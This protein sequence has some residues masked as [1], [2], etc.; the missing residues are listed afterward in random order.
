MRGCFIFILFIAFLSWGQQT[1]G[2]SDCGRAKI[3]LG[4]T[5]FK[6]ALEGYD[7]V[8]YE[9]M[10]WAK[11]NLPDVESGDKEVNGII[12]INGYRGENIMRTFH[13]EFLFHRERW[14]ADDKDISLQMTVRLWTVVEDRRIDLIDRH[15]KVAG[16]HE[17]QKLLPHIKTVFN[18]M[19]AVLAA[20]MLPDKVSFDFD[21]KLVK[22]DNP[23]DAEVRIEKIFTRHGLV[24]TEP[25]G[26]AYYC[27]E[28]VPEKGHMKPGAIFTEQDWNPK[29]GDRPPAEPYKMTYDT[30]E[31]CDECLKTDRYR[32]ERPETKFR[33]KLTK[34]F[35]QALTSH[36]LTPEKNLPVTCNPDIKAVA[37]QPIAPG[38][39]LPVPFRVSG[40]KDKVIADLPVEA[41]VSPVHLGNLNQDIARTDS[42]GMTGTLTFTAASNAGEGEVAS[43]TGTICR[44]TPEEKSAIQAF[45]VEILPEIEALVRSD[46]RID[47]YRDIRSIDDDG[48]DHVHKQYNADETLMLEFTVKFDQRYTQPHIDSAHGFKG[49]VLIYR[50][51]A[52][53]ARLTVTNPHPSSEIHQRR[54]QFR[55]SDCGVMNYDFIPYS[56]D[57][58][59]DVN[60]ARFDLDVCYFH[61]IPAPDSAARTLPTEGLY[62][63]QKNYQNPAVSIKFDM[64]SKSYDFN[65]Q[66]CSIQYSGYPVPAPSFPYVVGN[67]FP[68]VLWQFAGTECYGMDQFVEPLKQTEFRDMYRKVK[69]DGRTFDDLTF[70]KTINLQKGD[71][72]MCWDLE[73]E[74]SGDEIDGKVQ[75][76][77]SFLYQVKTLRGRFSF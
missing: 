23:V 59:I 6:N 63:L 5:F 71:R 64:S 65:G 62:F 76:K 61:Y 31:L 22:A 41:G 60:Q 49:E 55:D 54:G 33:I 28:V 10:F 38:E 25:G 68:L 16:R 58:F 51:T 15:Y 66:S 24:A 9:V 32:C 73:E 14:L 8:D 72:A 19:P 69:S 30:Q 36:F 4:G 18:E 77:V 2:S 48:F 74:E 7:P 26:D 43:V 53:N 37:V 57:H 21:P 13:L 35:N 1:M 12:Y 56:M 42:G 75:G 34:A 52:R 67:T 40:Y 50:G 11:E 20:S 45:R 44:G 39:T 27:F 46:H 3:P 47:W 70:T 29:A 17:K